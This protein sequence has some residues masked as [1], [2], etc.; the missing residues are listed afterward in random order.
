M[1]SFFGII[2]QVKNHTHQNFKC[3]TSYLKNILHYT[4]LEKKKQNNNLL[5]L[6]MLM[7]CGKKIK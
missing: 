1:G 7:I 5:V 3:N 6:L 2:D 4:K